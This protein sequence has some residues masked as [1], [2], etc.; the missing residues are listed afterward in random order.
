MQNVITKSV[1][2]NE[3]LKKIQNFARRE[4]SVDEIYVFNVALCNNDID[5][6]FE[7]FSLDA[8][9]ELAPMFVG[10]TG[11]FDHSMK[12][13]D[14]KARIFETYVEKVEGKF[15]KDGEAFYQL[16]A[17]AYM[18]NSEENKALI[19][20]IDTGIKKEVSV[21]CSVEKS[22]CSICNKDNRRTSCEHRNGN[23]YNDKLC[24]SI[25]ENPTDAYEF[26][27]VAVPAQREAGIKKSFVP[28]EEQNM[29]EIITK[30]SNCSEEVV[31]TKSQARQISSYIDDLKLDADLGEAYKKNLSKEIVEVFRKA[32]P[33]VDENL[34]ASITSVMTTKELLGF[35]D[36]IKKEKAV[37][38]QKPQ[39]A[40][41]TKQNKNDY[42]QFKI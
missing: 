35:R 5:R 16:C 14:Q 8:L 9:N 42:S 33:N 34:F 39:F 4:L 17:K 27:F 25:L 6:D 26:S 19:D 13:S 1:A 24:Y 32:F 23:R 29:N 18:L 40:S 30:M 31:L 2:S 28:M 10:K 7:K 20:E 3:D 11:I 15:T 36:G 37:A 12:T 41:S 21:S 38:N 22:I